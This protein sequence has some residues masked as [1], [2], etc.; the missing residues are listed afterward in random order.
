MMLA[1]AG[2]DEGQ[3]GSFG[4]I[5]PD[6]R[7]TPPPTA[8]QDESGEFP[9]VMVKLTTRIICVLGFWSPTRVFS[10]FNMDIVVSVIINLD[11]TTLPVSYCIAYSA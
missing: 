7:L 4:S 9:G 1:R 2:Q 10:Q 6:Y 5:Q 8:T 3:Y 11:F